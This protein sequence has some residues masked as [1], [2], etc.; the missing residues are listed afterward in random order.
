MRKNLMPIRIRQPL[1]VM[2]GVALALTA[3]LPAPAQPRFTTGDR[4][5]CDWLQN[6]RPDTGTVVPFTSTDLDQSGRWYRVRLDKEKIP[7]ATVECMADRLRAAP[8]ASAPTSGDRAT[9]PAPIQAQAPAPIPANTAPR[10]GQ[11]AAPAPTPVAVPATPTVRAVPGTPTAPAG[12]LPPLPGTAWKI[13]YGRGKTGDVFLFCSTGT[14]Q[15]V[16]ASGSIGAVGKS[17]RVAGSTLTTV[18]R[19]DGRVQDWSMSGS[20]GVM[21]IREPRQSLKLHYNGTTQCR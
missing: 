9:L 12:P 5:Q 18:N 1:A 3:A 2:L 7:N 16:P 21:E 10:T 8:A 13:D 4:V 11:P 14:W 6:G 15:I 17:Y 20:D 19:D